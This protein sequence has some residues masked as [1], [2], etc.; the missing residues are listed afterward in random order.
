QPPRPYRSSLTQPPNLVPHPF[1]SLIVDRVGYRAQRD[2]TLIAAPTSPRKT[3][4]LALI[5]LAFS[6]PSVA[7]TRTIPPLDAQW[8]FTQSNPQGASEA[9]FDDK[10]WQTV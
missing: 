3:M 2:R 6:L 9:A 8:R 1:D 4:R 5:A 10:T 7:Q